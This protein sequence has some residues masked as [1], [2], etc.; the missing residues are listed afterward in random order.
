VTA[1]LGDLVARLTLEQKVNLL[2][3]QDW[4]SLPAEPA[5]GL[6]SLVMSDGPAGV[7]GT[8][9]SEL[10]PSASLPSPTALAASWDVEL[11]DRVT[12]LL[13]SEARRKGVDVV[14]GPTVNL[15]RS[16]L[17]GRHFEAFSEDP[18]LTGVL[19]TAY[20]RGLQRRGVGATPKHYVAN[21]SET[22][23]H[24]VDIQLDERTLHELYLAPFERMVTD[25]GA[26]LVMAAYNGVNGAT[27]TENPLLASPLKDRW[28][29]DGVVVSDWFATKSTAPSASAAL[30][31]VMPGPAG[32]WG[33]ALLKAVRNGDVA[34][35][36]VDD[37]VLRLL[38][39]ASRVGALDGYE[40]G[41]PE[42][43]DTLAVLR[44][45]AGDGMVLLRND[46]VL[47]LARSG[48]VAVLGLL[49]DQARTQGGGSASVLPD[50]VVSPLAGLRAALG[51]R[52]RYEVGV[53]IGEGLPPL[54]MELLDGPIDVRWLTGDGAVPRTEQ[55]KASR[56]VWLGG[57]PTGAAELEV[58]FRLRPDVDGE[59]RLGVSGVG[60]FEMTLDGETILAETLM[61]TRGDLE[62]AMLGP[63]EAVVGRHLV[64][65]T[66]VAVTVRRDIP[67]DST[68]ASLVLGAD[69]PHPA[70]D[71]ELAAAVELARD[72]D[73]AV[74]VVGTT[75][76]VES[77]GFDRHDLALP[78]GQDELVRAVAAVAPRTIVV[79]N[80]GGPVLLPW[81]DDVAAVL[82][83]WFG[84]QE[85]GSALAD[86]LLGERE[87]GGRL[88][89]TWPATQDD[90]P[91]L[92]T[93]PKDGVLRYAEGVHI[94]Y[95]AWLRAGTTPAFPFGHGLGYT[96]WEYLDLSG[97]DGKFVVRLRNSGARPGKEVVQLYASRDDSNVDRPV[98]WL[99]GFAVVTAD[100]GAEVT[101]T[102]DVPPRA[103]EYS[104]GSAW[105]LE[106]GTYTVSA[107]RS[108]VDLP[109]TTTLTFSNPPRP[110]PTARPSEPPEA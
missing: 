103:L 86:V 63:P 41:T 37:K 93:T 24:T 29:F 83:T 32:P 14:L 79:V 98:R 92:S 74:V 27:M 28:R 22:E 81:R 33:E 25:G 109:L 43:V 4:W 36:T 20:V 106:L 9:W 65:G 34:E 15:H 73:T 84:G 89:T 78:G 44:D 54:P 77:E 19:G 80:S 107:G 60:R 88:P 26:W 85:L 51:D 13:A 1:E 94:G 45:A 17:G 6:R 64:A 96:T 90:V 46:G 82:L 97:V 35:S 31:V 8:T 72:C 75:E 101:A 49:A 56:L 11:M 2:T 95:R 110:L 100:P 50:H 48:T 108:V 38:R 57:V 52:V 21:E 42:P 99:V 59:W 40:A 61:P 102:I 104:T 30:D 87:P 68:A 16:P 105:A 69:R 53:R 7:R 10:S 39:L 18:L 67:P 70:A 55:R 12:G 5:I 66:E 62:S 3:G 76:R 71:V 47:P 91:V 58:S 23:R